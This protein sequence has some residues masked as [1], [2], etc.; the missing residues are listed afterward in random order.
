MTDTVTFN[1]VPNNIRVPGSY[2]EFNAG[3]SPFQGKS[4][5]LLIGQKTN[6]GSAPVNAP[7]L[8][9]G[10][11]TALFGPGSMLSDMA[12]YARQGY[13][14]GEIWCLP[15]ADPGGVAAKK[16]VTIGVG[17]L[18]NSGTLVLE[19]QGETVQV[20]VAIT[21]ADTDV[22]TNLAAAI[23]QGY[24]KFGRT[25]SF[26]VIAAVD[27]VTLN[28]VNL[29][30]RNVGALGNAIA[31]DKDLIGNE[32]PLAAFIT[33]ASPTAGT[34]IPT[35]DAGLAALGDMEFDWI[36]SP[37]ADATTLNTIQQFLSDRW[38]PMEEIYGNYIT[39]LFASFA[40]LATA[41]AARN[42]PNADIMGVVESSSPPWVWA[43]ALAAAVAQDKNLGTTVD[44]AYTI[45]RPLTGLPLVGVKPPKSRL[46]WFDK[47]QRNQLLF[48]GISTFTVAADGTVSIER[49]ITTYQTNTGG[50][51]DMTWLDVETR[52]QAV[53]FGR[54][55]KQRITAS[56]PRCVL[57]DDNPSNNPG[58]VTVPI[59]KAEFIHIYKELEAGG[60]V[61]NSDLFAQ[62]LVVVRS[63]DPTRV[64][65]YLPFDVANQFN[66]LAVNAT[67]FLEFPA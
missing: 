22:A 2:F 10:D 21:D 37:Y 27:G 20:P 60:L 43:A 54:Y 6:A 14:I 63:A 39:T 65:A 23:N 66:V 8:L 42:D 57:A 19:I 40:N 62:R 32:G 44:Q 59:L 11:P 56:F 31:V 30:A 48:D 25:M 50:Q 45:S 49:L 46:N 41:G 67:T 47:T 1:Q 18:A 28:Q 5:T 35:L 53:Y 24:V 36:G 4:R 58:I 12:I 7:I 34:L 55:N 15:L 61:D 9:N 26:A 38:G 16:T 13:P 51:P 52:A 33:I 64:D 17:I 3:Q 29:T